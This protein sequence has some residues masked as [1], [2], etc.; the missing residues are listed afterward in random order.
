MRKF[1]SYRPKRKHPLP[2]PEITAMVKRIDAEGYQAVVSSL[3]NN[4]EKTLFRL[5]IKHGRRTPHVHN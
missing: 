5:A 4:Y 3:Q 1:T 2:P